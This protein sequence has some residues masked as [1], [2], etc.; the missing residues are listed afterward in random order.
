MAVV[1]AGCLAGAVESAFRRPPRLLYVALAVVVL[2]CAV[3][4]VRRTAR[5]ARGLRAR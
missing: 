4:I 1:T 2:G 3:T 5:I